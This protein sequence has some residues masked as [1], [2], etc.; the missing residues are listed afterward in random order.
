MRKFG[1]AVTLVAIGITGVPLLVLL[2]FNFLW[3]FSAGL[4]GAFAWVALMRIGVRRYRM[5]F[6]WFF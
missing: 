3:E 2:K 5:K 6:C 4:L 1:L